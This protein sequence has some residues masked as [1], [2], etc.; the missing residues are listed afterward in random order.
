[1]ATLSEPLRVVE[2]F[3]G[4]GG[5]HYA[6]QR[7]GVPHRVVQA[8]DVDDSAVRTYRHNLP[9]TPVSTKNIVSLQQADLQ[10]LAADCWLLSPPCQ[11]HTRQGLQ[12][13]ESDGRA[14]ALAR[15]VDL[16]EAADPPLLPSSLLLENVV[17][18][19][20][21]STRTRLRAVLLGRGYSVR[22]L[23]AS[24]AQIG[25][26]NQRTRYFLLASRRSA[27]EPLSSYLL[28]HCGGDGGAEG[29]AEAE[30]MAGAAVAE[31][32]LERYGAAMDLVSRGSPRSCC[33]T[34][35]HPRSVKAPGSLL[36]DAAEES[37]DAEAAEAALPHSPR[38][39]FFL[40][41][42]VANLHG[43][44]PHFG[45]PPEVSTRK[46]YELLGNSLSV[47][48]VATLLRYLL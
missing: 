10:R 44:P 31:H 34:K 28:P 29:G 14:A 4:I 3:A 47:Q 46:Q 17:G 42:E 2:F 36:Y 6:L 33:S 25:V 8:F 35:T 32:V 38:P 5:L 11:P 48:V 19:E 16:L 22:E 1:M 30:A 41:R 43:F 23:W 45:F 24:P 13:A 26:P 40:P 37:R 18:F 21:S 7:S 15:L 12:L 20:S 27:C 39:R 9:R